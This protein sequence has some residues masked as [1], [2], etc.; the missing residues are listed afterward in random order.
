LTVAAVKEEQSQD[1]HY[2]HNESAEGTGNYRDSA[3]MIGGRGL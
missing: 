3:V 1:Y 2:K